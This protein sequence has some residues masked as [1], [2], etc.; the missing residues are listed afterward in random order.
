MDVLTDNRVAQHQQFYPT[1][2][3]SL[4][5]HLIPPAGSIPR[6]AHGVYLSSGSYLG[7]ALYCQACTPGG[8]HNTQPVV[9]PHTRIQLETD[10]TFFANGRGSGVCPECGSRIHTVKNAT[11]WVCAECATEFAAS[12][13]SIARAKLEA[14]QKEAEEEAMVASV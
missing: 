4:A 10:W 7:R 11:R 13:G 2:P 14:M 6:C 12:A 8:P 9:L 3:H 5:P 1:S